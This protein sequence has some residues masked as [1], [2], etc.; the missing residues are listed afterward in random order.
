MGTIHI[1]NLSTL[2][3]RAACALVG[4]YWIGELSLEEIEK[5][6]NV[7]IKKKGHTFTV[8]DKEKD[9]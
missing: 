7:K 1:K 6:I 2:S 3:D 5:S 4:Q 8:L 9:R